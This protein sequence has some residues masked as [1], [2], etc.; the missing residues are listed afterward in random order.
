VEFVRTW[1]P[2]VSIT[3]PI[4]TLIGIGVTLWQVVKSRSAAEAA[5][6]SVDRASRKFYTFK[7]S[8]A[9]KLSSELPQ[10]LRTDKKVLAIDR[11]EALSDLISEILEDTS[12]PEAERH[13]LRSAIEDLHRIARSLNEDNEIT[14]AMADFAQA[15][16]SRLRG[17]RANLRKQMV[18]PSQNGESREET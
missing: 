14:P 3:A 11:A 2:F 6:K 9:T 17:I 12:L 5:K 4:L 15:L 7:L 1:T 8:R 10:L 13:Y 16:R 18:K